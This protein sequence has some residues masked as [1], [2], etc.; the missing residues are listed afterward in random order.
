MTE[1]VLPFLDPTALS[2]IE[3]G[4]HP[5]VA[6]GYNESGVL[7]T[8]GFARTSSRSPERLSEGWQF[9]GLVSG[10]PVTPS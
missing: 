1:P 4:T 7:I 6:V 2:G 5:V 3:L 8:D 9:D 10:T